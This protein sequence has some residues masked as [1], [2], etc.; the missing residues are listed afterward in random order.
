[1]T[2]LSDLKYNFKILRHIWDVNIPDIIHRVRFRVLVPI[3]MF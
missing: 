2:N 3:P 1:M